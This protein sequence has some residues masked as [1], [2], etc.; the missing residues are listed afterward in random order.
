VLRTNPIFT[1]PPNRHEGNAS[2]SERIPEIECLVNVR[3]LLVANAQPPELFTDRERSK[4]RNRRYSQMQGREE[5]FEREHHNEPAPGW[6]CCELACAELDQMPSC[7]TEYAAGGTVDTM[8]CGKRAVANC[9]DCGTSRD[10]LEAWWTLLQFY[11]VS[12][13]NSLRSAHCFA[14]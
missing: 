14:V 8:P 10:S 12:S 13:V 7:Q 11:Y 5:L 6:H 9:A 2:K 1:P 3:P 4:I